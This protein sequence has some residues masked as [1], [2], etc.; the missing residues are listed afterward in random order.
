M[1]DKRKDISGACFDLVTRH[2]SY[3]GSGTCDQI[4]TGTQYIQTQLSRG[5]ITCQRGTLVLAWVTC[6]RQEEQNPN[7]VGSASFSHIYAPVIL[8]WR[9]NPLCRQMCLLRRAQE[10][11]KPGHT[12][13]TASRQVRSHLGLGASYLAASGGSSLD[14]SFFMN[15]G[16]IQ[17]CRCAQCLLINGILRKTILQ[18]EVIANIS[19]CWIK[20]RVS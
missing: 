16:P 13:H 6:W 8:Q 17:I 12:S 1:L 10:A 7:D 20:S 14:A 4:K 3:Q 19:P 2:K 15:L 11:P 5:K 18:L 9:L